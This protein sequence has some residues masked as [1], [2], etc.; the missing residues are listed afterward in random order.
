[1]HFY[2]SFKENLINS[3]R[4]GFIRFSFIMQAFEFFEAL[5]QRLG[6]LVAHTF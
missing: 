6:S 4:L 2:F 1:M 5:V 3:L